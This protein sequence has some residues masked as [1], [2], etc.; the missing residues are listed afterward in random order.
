M[1]LPQYVEITEVGP[2]DGLQNEKSILSTEQKIL[3]INH[4]IKSGCKR[5]EVASFVSPKWVPQL[6]D[7]AEVFSQLIKIEDLFLIA[8]IPNAKGLERALLAGVTDIAVFTAASDLFNQKNINM[9]TAAS[10]QVIAEIFNNMPKSI[11][12]KR[13]YISTAFAC[14]YAGKT[15]PVKVLFLAEKLLELGADEIVLGDTIGVAVPTD[16]ENLLNIILK[17]IAAEKIALHFH[18]T[19]G[20]ALANVFTALQM[21]ILKFDGSVG[22]LGGCPYAQ[23]ASGNVA[24]EELVYLFEN[25]N[26]STGIKIDQLLETAKEIENLLAHQLPSKCLATYR[27]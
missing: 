23:G 22:G 6:A 19:R 25:M 2:R 4:L 3:F 9:D 20:T 13:A 26:I 8:L 11:R 24:T 1:K 16:V 21:G 15:D 27:Q 10:L 7:A 18:D 14:P 5:I 12:L 17:N